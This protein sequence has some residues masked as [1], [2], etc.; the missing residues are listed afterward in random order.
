MLD[1]YKQ[2]LALRK[3]FVTYSDRTCKARL[4]EGKIV[5]QVPAENPVLQVE[6]SLAGDGRGLG[7]SPPETTLLRSASDGYEVSVTDLRA[8]SEVN[9][10]TESAA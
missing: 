2:L 8:L 9:R 5:F 10:L 3:Q 4:A 1:W 6:V 7:A